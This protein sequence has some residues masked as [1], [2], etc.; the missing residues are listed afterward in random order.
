MRRAIVPGLL[1]LAGVLAWS[2]GRAA[3]PDPALFAF[4]GSF[5][6]PASA[7][8]AGEALA[9][10]WLGDLP[11]D[12]PAFTAPRGLEL[13][14]VL[15]HG[16][17]QDL[18]AANR[19][20][21]ETTAFVEAAGGWIALP[22]GRA[23]LF[24]YAH[25]PVLRREENAFTRGVLPVDPANPPA[26]ITSSTDAREIRAGGG[27]SFGVSALRAGVAA[28]WT[29]RD[30]RYESE[31]QSGS[32]TAGTLTTTLS[33]DAVG[34]QGGL[35]L[36]LGRS[37]SHP[38][39]LGAG[40]RRV[41]ALSLTGQDV[42]VPQVAGPTVTT[43]YGVSR[44]ASWEGGVSARVGLAPAFALV[45]GV[46]GRGAQDWSG[47]GVTSGA[48]TS[49]GVAGVYHDPEEDWT[50]RFGAGEDEQEGV[51]EPRAGVFSLGFGWSSGGTRLEAG[52][53]R[54]AV[55]H[56]SGPTSYD[57]RFVASVGVAF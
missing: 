10:R 55:E 50:V 33:G 22:L 1:A 15:L 17:R 4:P 5:A 23:A 46:G 12:N 43:D 6:N 2:P 11:F 27:I 40:A 16:S 14:P 13:S 41:P 18:R 8:S 7:I 39:T 19:N 56:G 35:R 26:A 49:W 34:M 47:L 30:D 38:F 37:G 20:F 24:A 29:R 31:E 25:Q 54:R 52:A 28:E 36:D 53:L 3:T 44:D 45:A 57:D 32:P 9:D 42:F 21:S 51:P 48:G